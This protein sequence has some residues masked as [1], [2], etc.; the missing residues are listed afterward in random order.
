MLGRSLKLELPRQV[1]GFYLF[2]SL[3]V[4]FWIAASSI[5]LA[6]SVS[7]EQ[8][9]QA[10]FAY[11]DNAATATTLEY[12]LNGEANLQPLVERFARENS[13]LYCGF[14]SNDRKFV[15]HSRSELVGETYRVATGSASRRGDAQV[16]RIEE[17]NGVTREYSVPVAT[18][19]EVVGSLIMAVD[20]PGL[21]ATVMAAA[22]YA[23]T[24]LLV[25]LLLIAVGA[26]VMQRSVRPV[27]AVES[28]LR[29]AAVSPTLV[30]AE[31]APIQSRG[32]SAFGWNRLLQEF[33]SERAAGGLDERLSGAVQAIRHEK[34]DDV[35][36]SL[37]D[38]IAITD[39]DGLITFANQAMGALFAPG[40]QADRLVGLTVEG[41]LQIDP[42]DDANDA[43]LDPNLYS[44]HLAHELI[45][46]RDGVEQNLRITRDPIRA[47]DRSSK[48]GH[49]WLAR[50]ITQQKLAEA[51]RDQFLDN[52]THELRTPLA[53]IKAYAETLSMGD[54]L[55]VESQKEFCNTINTE[56]TRLGRFIDDLLSVSSMEAGSLTLS[57]QTVDLERLFSEVVN[58]VK[59][60][61][62]QKGQ[63]LDAV[64]PEKYPQLKLDK[65]KINVALVNLIG[66]A[67]KYTPA[68]GNIRFEVKLTDR[69][70]RIE[71]E[72]SGVGISEEELPRIFE[73]FFRSANPRVQEV[74]G[75]G[76]GLSMAHEV[77]KLHGGDLT[78]Q[79]TVG[80]G[81]TFTA[82]L[83]L[84]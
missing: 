12:V 58:K 39:Q 22:R 28:Q 55:D 35:L 43:L 68:N 24:V 27:A 77:I 41:S 48:A 75:T 37:T 72:D 13:L 20:E 74:T 78:V 1:V 38:G 10:A 15:A 23:P 65:D 7:N 80:H 6:R 59:P 62:D 4:A 52:A 66:N 32:A 9:E 54:S 61:I 26:I 50:D 3:L 16:V 67:T 31:L 14:A 51:M 79:S 56:A 63:T 81:T 53:N 83:P 84:E 64:F 40:G 49:V 8:F 18:K 69:A 47:A 76:L 21:L 2:F 19:D 25:P 17:A 60:Q 29:R 36:N 33:T 82:A 70:I 71:V 45:R 57:R 42:D 73:K 11:V 44:R 5:F 34:S 46:D 30:D